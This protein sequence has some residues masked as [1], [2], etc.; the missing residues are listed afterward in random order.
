MSARPCF[1]P[2][3][4]GMYKEGVSELLGQGVDSQG[5]TKTLL[6]PYESRINALLRLWLSTPGLFHTLGMN[7]LSYPEATISLI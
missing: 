4:T 3:T 6:R 1:M 5:F 2:K 7:T